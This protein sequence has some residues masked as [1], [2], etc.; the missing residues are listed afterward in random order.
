MAATAAATRSRPR[1]DR[2][3]NASLQLPVHDPRPQ[4]WGPSCL[5]FLPLTARF[6][7]I[8]RCQAPFSQVQVIQLCPS[9]APCS[10][11]GPWMARR[12]TPP[13]P[14]SARVHLVAAPDTSRPLP[15]RGDPPFRPCAARVPRLRQPGGGHPQRREFPGVRRCRP[16][17]GSTSSAPP[18]SCWRCTWVPW[19][20]CSPAS[21]AGR[22]WR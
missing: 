3:W 11:P 9:G 8:E 12:R 15:S 22:P 10:G 19:R 13:L 5:F 21:G 20:P 17:S 1:G 14:T 6:R 16:N 2:R 7:A 4:E 18:A